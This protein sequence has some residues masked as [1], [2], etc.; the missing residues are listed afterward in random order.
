LA[1]GKLDRAALPAPPLDRMAQEVA[2]AA[3][4]TSVEEALAEL[5]QEMLHLAESPSIHDDF[6]ALGGHSLLAT[7]VV[8]RISARF[9]T[10]LPLRT[11][12]AGPTIAMLAAWIEHQRWQADTGLEDSAREVTVI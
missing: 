7:Q 3:P 8:S 6:F 1:N 4:R 5:W 12:F 2:Y 9:E 11:F 10:E